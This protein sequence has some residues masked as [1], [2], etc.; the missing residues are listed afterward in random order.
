MY[1]L[2][3]ELKLGSKTIK[4]TYRQARL[5]Q[6]LSNNDNHTPIY[7]CSR[8]EAEITREQNK[9]LLG[10]CLV[11]EVRV[12]DNISETQAVIEAEIKRLTDILS[13][14][15]SSTNSKPIKYFN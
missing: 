11:E 15:H 7:F 1:V 4:Q 3:K 9:L 10:E 5:G 12:D 14:W 8:T 6:E 2:T 13:K